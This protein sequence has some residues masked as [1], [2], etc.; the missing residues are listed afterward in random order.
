MTDW[1]SVETR[2]VTVRMTLTNQP[3]GKQRLFYDDR[4]HKKALLPAWRPR[5]ISEALD[6]PPM[7]YIHHIQLTLS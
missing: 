6:L 7:E 1:A 3:G 4:H 2:A 5:T